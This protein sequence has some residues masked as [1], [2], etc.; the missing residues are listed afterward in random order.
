[1][2]HPG[3]ERIL[4]AAHAARISG[5]HRA[6]GQRGHAA[7]RGEQGAVVGVDPREQVEHGRRVAAAQP[8][9]RASGAQS[10]LRA[11]PVV[12][13]AQQLAARRARI[14]AGVDAEGEHERAQRW[15]SMR[16]R[17][18]RLMTRASPS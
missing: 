13:G 11:L 2:I 4:M 14:I 5:T 12:G 8:G 3:E 9:R 1:V 16:W 15:P 18:A 7:R 10:D 6:V 17:P